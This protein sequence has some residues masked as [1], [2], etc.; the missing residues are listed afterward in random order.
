M[1]CLSATQCPYCNLSA[2]LSQSSPTFSCI[3]ALGCCLSWVKGHAM[4][5]EG[6]WGNSKLLG[7]LSNFFFPVILRRGDK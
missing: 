2:K 4:P 6:F 1:I 7:K 3:S 5:T